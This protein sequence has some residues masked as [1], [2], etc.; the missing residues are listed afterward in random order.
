MSR[1]ILQGW[2]LNWTQ[3]YVFTSSTK[4]YHKEKWKTSVLLA[5]RVQCSHLIL[6]S[7][8]VTSTFSV[9]NNLFRVWFLVFFFHQKLKA[10]FIAG[11]WGMPSW[12]ESWQRKDTMDYGWFSLKG[13]SLVRPLMEH[14]VWGSKLTEGGKS[15]K[16]WHDKVQ[17]LF[18]ACWYT[19]KSDILLKGLGTWVF[20][21]F[22]FFIIFILA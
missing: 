1:E 14:L 10:R 16:C 17:R 18:G 6:I 8:P 11:I 9:K 12:D 20:W 3:H 7:L 21:T 2:I 19:Q 4:D 22:F 13:I 15:T 5:C